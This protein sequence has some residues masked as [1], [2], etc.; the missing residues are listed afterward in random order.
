MTTKD[1][2]LAFIGDSYVNGSGDSGCLGWIGRLCKK[3]FN[4]PPR[5][6]FYDLGIPGELTDSLRLRWEAEVAR[7]YPPPPNMHVV[8]MCGLNDTAEVI[9]SGVLLPPAQTISNAEAIV[10]RAKEKYPILWIGMPPVNQQM[11]PMRVNE[12]ITMV[13]DQQRAIAVNEAMGLSAAQMGVPF[14]DILTPLL[15]S[16]DYMES[17]TEGDGLHPSARGYE[18]ISERVDDWPAWQSWFSKD[19]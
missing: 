11:S 18:I 1:L 9:G 16:R 10:R 5:L 12:E 3:R 15:Q 17:Q 4:P 8:L 13:F 7:R 6:W 2:G 19:A 14:L